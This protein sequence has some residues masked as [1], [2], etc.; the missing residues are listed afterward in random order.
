MKKQLIYFGYMVME[1]RHKAMKYKAGNLKSITIF[2]LPLLTEIWNLARLLRTGA[3]NNYS[4]T[5][6]S[7]TSL[8]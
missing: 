8:G 6:E 3:K 4:E 1:G 7:P 2:F 5:I